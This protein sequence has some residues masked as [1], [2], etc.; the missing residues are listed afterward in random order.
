MRYPWA[1]NSQQPAWVA[2]L[3]GE[4][5]QSDTRLGLGGGF[6]PQL[7]HALPGSAD[8]RPSVFLQMPLPCNVRTQKA[9][10]EGCRVLV[11]HPH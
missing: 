2:W 7:A 3:V 6:R 9:K 8:Q 1:G 4:K 11:A 10:R 5:V